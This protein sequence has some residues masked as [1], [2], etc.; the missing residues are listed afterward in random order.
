MLY[1]YNAGEGHEGTRELHKKIAQYNIVLTP[2]A[3]STHTHGS[4]KGPYDYLT[5]EKNQIVFTDSYGGSVG[6]DQETFF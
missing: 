5:K 3:V 1:P 4:W 6:T 2:E